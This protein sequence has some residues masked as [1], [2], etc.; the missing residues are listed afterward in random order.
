MEE[1]I[2][3]RNG[4][5]RLMC[6]V[7]MT[8]MGTAHLARDSKALGFTMV[9]AGA[10]KVAEGIFLY[11][12]VKA[13]I[14]SNVK[15]AVASTF[16]EYMDGETLMN[17]FNAAYQENSQNGQ[18]KSSNSSGSNSTGGGIGQTVSQVAGAVSQAANAVQSATSSMSQNGSNN[19]QNN[20]KNKNT[21]NSGNS[22]T[23]PS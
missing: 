4:F 21:K 6:G 1:N 8:A 3:E 2:S 23:N 19:S 16:D 20:S 14:N 18:S 9:A 15:G 13:M 7:A 11:C 22:A 12:P 5:M 10:M 17:A